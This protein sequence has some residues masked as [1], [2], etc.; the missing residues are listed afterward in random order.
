[1]RHI[2]ICGLPRSTIFF[3]LSHK[4]HDFRGKKVT[5]QKMCFLIFCTTFVWNIS[6]SKKNWARYDQKCISVCMWSAGYCCQ[7][8]MRLEFSWHFLWKLLKY[9]ILRRSVSGSRVVPRGRTHMR[10]LTVSFR[11]FAK[12]AKNCWLNTTAQPCVQYK[13]V[14]DWQSAAV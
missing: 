3:T 4:R 6:H 5:E 7:I 12:A 14:A 9:R 2:A 10:K 1:M 8:V 11:S 13:S